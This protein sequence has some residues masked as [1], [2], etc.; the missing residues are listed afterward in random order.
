[1]HKNR[2]L[3]ITLAV[4]GLGLLVFVVWLLGTHGAG[5]KTYSIDGQY[6]V[7]YKAYNYN[8]LRRRFHKKDQYKLFI[9]DELQ[10]RVL[11]TEKVLMRDI[12]GFN[13][14]F[15]DKESRVYW[16]LDTLKWFD[17]PRPIDV[18]GVRK[19]ALQKRERQDAIRDSIWREEMRQ[20]EM[21]DSIR[22][23]R[24][25][26]EVRQQFR[27]QQA[28][29]PIPA[30]DVAWLEPVIRPWLDF[31]DIDLA[32]A[33][34]LGVTK[35]GCVN[36]LREPADGEAYYYEFNP[37]DD[38]PSLVAMSYSPNRQRYVD[39]SICVEKDENGVWH[40]TGM[41]DVD[42]AVFL[43]DRRRKTKNLLIYNGSDGHVQDVFWKGNDVFVMV[44]ATVWDV[45]MFHIEVY[46]I[47]GRTRK[48]YEAMPDSYTQRSYT[49][50]VYLPSR[51]IVP[52]ELEL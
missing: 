41:Y 25:R 38:T 43:V 46:D 19:A 48:T 17:L 29:S 39:L 37:E 13:L 52:Y 49:N 3:K 50:N 22:R 2:L 44:S 35:G 34:Q 4:C 33:M 40:D 6:S 21:D 20:R 28:K 45:E 16:G 47:P 1:M 14:H 32:Q 24:R 5:K 26:V 7:Y 42:Q 9:V 18:E 27:E 10:H 15:S 12:M 31:Y 51:R 23:E 30:E 36:C 11:H 8:D